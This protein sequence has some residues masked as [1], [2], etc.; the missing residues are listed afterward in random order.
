MRE[1]CL[2]SLTNIRSGSCKGDCK[3]CTQSIYWGAKI[4]RYRWK[5]ISQI[6]EEAERAWEVGASGFCLVTSGIELDPHS[7]PRLQKMIES[8]KKRLPQLKLIG[9]FGIAEKRELEELKKA[10]LS[11]YNHNLESSPSFY[12][13]LVTTHRWEE[14]FKTAQLVKEVGLELFSGGI[15]GVGEDK[16]DWEEM[17]KALKKLDPEVIPLNFFIPNPALPL[18]RTH[19]KEM[20]LEVISLFREAFPQSVIMLAGGR[21]LVFGDK[22]VEGIKAG[23]DGI[24]IGN[25]L[26]TGGDA[27][28]KDWK[29]IRQYG[30]RVKNARS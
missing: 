11:A 10:G 9:C 13:R 2:C 14:R 18:E 28:H 12:P 30:I 25:Y 29:V 16:R 20:A 27:P 4:E 24:I 21:E 26:T 15:F 19:S 3:F 6:V 8:L 22:W 17:I 1:I 7:L 23:A 5:P